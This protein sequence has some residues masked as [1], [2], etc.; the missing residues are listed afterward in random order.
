MFFST[1]LRRFEW[2]IYKVSGIEF[3]TPGIFLLFC[4]WW[5]VDVSS[6]CRPFSYFFFFFS[7]L[8]FFNFVSGI[9]LLS[10]LDNFF[11]F[12]GGKSEQDRHSI[13]K[14]SRTRV[15][16]P[17]EIPIFYPAQP[18]VCCFDLHQHYHKY[19]Y[20][21]SSMSPCASICQKPRTK[22]ASYIL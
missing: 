11:F 9:S 4:K 7:L 6:L 22:F 15:F 14:S 17:Q 2:F 20:S 21:H 1:K 10:L 12:W 13:T 3:P 8:F 19:S 18:H 16:N 5:F